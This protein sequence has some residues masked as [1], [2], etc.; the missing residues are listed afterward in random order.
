MSDSETSSDIKVKY[1]NANGE[2]L[3]EDKNTRKNISSDTDYYFNIIAN[4][5]RIYS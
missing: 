1:E 5:F 4:N 3:L 2:N